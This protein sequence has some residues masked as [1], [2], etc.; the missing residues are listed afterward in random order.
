MNKFVYNLEEKKFVLS[1][2]YVDQLLTKSNDNVIVV[3]CDFASENI[4]EKI[5][6]FKNK[7]NGRADLEI[8]VNH[9]KDYIYDEAEINKLQ[10]I[11]DYCRSL[12]LKMAVKL[13]DAQGELKNVIFAKNEIEDF[14]N[15]YDITLEKGWKV[16]ISKSVK[17]MLANKKASDV[18]GDYFD[19]WKNI[20]KELNK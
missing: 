4:V 5:E 17:Q 1:N 20:F 13:N 10:K 8:V 7:I 19:I 15:K 18:A 11:D 3:E 6:E 14:A 16:E 12:N 9:K 2:D